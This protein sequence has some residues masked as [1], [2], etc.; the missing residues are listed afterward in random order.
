MQ[1]AVEVWGGTYEQICRT[2]QLA[3]ARGVDGFYYGESLTDL[4]LDA[5]Q[6]LAGLAGCT[7]SLS[8]GPVITYLLPQYRSVALLAKQATTLQEMSAGRL[9]FRTGCGGGRKHAASWWDPY[10]VDYPRAAARVDA[11]AEGLEI[12]CSLW[13]TGSARSAGPHFPYAGGAQ[14]LPRRRIPITLA[15]SRPRMLR[16]AARHADIC[17]LSYLELRSYERLRSEVERHAMGR[18][19]RFSLEVDGF[20]A[21]DERRVAALRDQ[22]GR[23][24]GHAA[25]PVWDRSL[26]GTPPQLRAQLRRYRDAGVDQLLV[27]LDDPFDRDAVELL[28]SA[29][30]ALR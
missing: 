6:V 26:N 13:T 18:S 2:A 1:L 30:A 25:G 17:E 10:G 20:V 23:M 12:L 28:A 27:A 5:W 21:R 7:K 8:L 22:I 19:L 14:R 15:A 29:M 24:R 9:V 16:L 3:E 4:D 11:L